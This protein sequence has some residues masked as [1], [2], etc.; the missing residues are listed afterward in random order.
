MN[1]LPEDSLQRFLQESFNTLERE[2]RPAFT[3]LCTTLS[4]LS[5]GFRVDEEEIYLTFLPDQ[6]FF[7]PLPPAEYLEITTSKAAVLALVDAELTLYEAVAHDKMIIRGDSRAIARFYDGLM[8][9][10]KGAVRS[11]TF[12]RL[13]DRFRY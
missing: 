5:L 8:L 9:Y 10:L 12:P 6:V 11:P 13:L 2:C 7:L 1:S 3:G 4:H